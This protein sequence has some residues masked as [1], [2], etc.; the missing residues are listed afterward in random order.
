LAQ[1]RAEGRHQRIMKAWAWL[2]ALAAGEAARSGLRGSAG[3][4]GAPPI[5]VVHHRHHVSV[6]LLSRSH[7]H[8]VAKRGV[9]VSSFTGAG[10]D[11]AYPEEAGVAAPA[12]E[13]QPPAQG[14]PA[15]SDVADAVF[16][17][18]GEAPTRE[19]MAA[20]HKR[21]AAATEHKPAPPYN[22]NLVAP[23]PPAPPSYNANLDMP[24]PPPLA[25]INTQNQM[26]KVQTQKDNSQQLAAQQIAAQQKAAQEFAAKERQA[27][28]DLQ[29]VKSAEAAKITNEV[30]AQ[31]VA[32][33]QGI[34]RPKGWDQCL[35]F[36]R[37]TKAQGVTGME[38]VKTWKATCEPAVSSGVATERY[39]VM[40]NALGGTV[41][42][43]A[44][45]QDYDVEKLC[46]AVLAV[47]HDVTAVDVKASS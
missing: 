16:G 31:A 41:E 42:P 27:Q 39:K 24:P 17:D 14:A 29:A 10:S 40:C 47:F 37:F 12:A 46:D 22:V 45:Q 3:H 28:L 13:P 36:S 21:A 18:A 7:S 35:K 19:E 1:E 20:V 33:P 4:G 15:D 32:A 25:T 6:S 9:D 38:L 34:T 23:A 43:F 30:T 8:H 5:T 26:Q 44:A 2:I 11:G